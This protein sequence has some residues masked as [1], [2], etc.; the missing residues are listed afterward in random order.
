MTRPRGNTYRSYPVC[1]HLGYASACR[2]SFPQLQNTV[3]GWIFTP[4]G[5]SLPS[6]LGREEQEGQ[7]LRGWTLVPFASLPVCGPIPK[8]VGREEPSHQSL[9][10]SILPARAA[11]A[12]RCSKRDD[13]SRATCPRGVFLL[14]PSSWCSHSP[15]PAAVPPPSTLWTHTAVAQQTGPC[16]SSIY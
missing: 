14:A 11:D 6:C 7:H 15:Q 1:M 16:L 9:W 4:S 5:S 13:Q 3:S 2:S 12:L 10:L 8:A